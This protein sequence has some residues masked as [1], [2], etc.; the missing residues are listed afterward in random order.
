MAETKLVNFRL[1]PDEYEGL[2][3]LS[4]LM[5]TTQADIVRNLIR[6]ELQK[7]EE[8]ITAYKMNLAELKTKIKL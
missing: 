6:M 1:Q 7:Q 2:K 5:E 4:E 8:A 3:I